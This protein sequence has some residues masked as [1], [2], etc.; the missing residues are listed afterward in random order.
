MVVITISIISLTLHDSYT[1]ISIKGIGIFEGWQ[2][3]ALPLLNLFLP[4]LKIFNDAVQKADIEVSKAQ[5][6]VYSYNVYNS[7]C[8]GGA[9][10]L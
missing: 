10:H 8:R 3:G 7:E 5:Y 2:R 4:P 9:Q 6:I 1:C